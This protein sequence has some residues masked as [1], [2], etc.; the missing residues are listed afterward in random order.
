MNRTTRHIAL[1]S[2]LF[3]LAA[4]AMLAQSGVDS[5]VVERVRQIE[6]ERRTGLASTQS[7]LKT[8]GADR[9]L[10]G[11]GAWFS[12][13]YID[14][15]D[16]DRSSATRDALDKL[17]IRDVRAWWATQ[18]GRKFSSYL[19][20]KTQNFDFRTGQG[21]AAPNFNILEK[22]DLDMGYVEFRPDPNQRVRAGRQFTQVGRGFVLADILDGLLYQRTWGGWQADAFW[23]T[24]PNRI[25]NIDSSI[26][27]FNQGLTHRDFAYLEAQYTHRAGNRYYMYHV[28]EVDRSQSLDAD[29]NRSLVDFGYNAN[30]T[31]I[32]GNVRV[33]PRVLLLT[34]MGLQGGSTLSAPAGRRVDVE[35]SF[36]EALGLWSL[37]GLNDGLV[38]AEYAYGSGD[39]DRA[40]VTDT[41]GGKQDATTDENFL[42][43]G[44]IETGLALSPRLSN[45]HIAR[46]G[47]Q[48]RLRMDGRRVHS[49]DPLVGLKFT[50]YYKV[51][52]RGAISDTLANN[53][54]SS[55]VGAAGDAYLAWRVWSDT[56]LNVQYGHF[57]PGNAY[58]V[59]RR[60]G[61]D[62]FLASTTLSF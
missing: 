17:N 40:N 9:F 47:Y 59:G 62:R 32:G 24:T 28:S 49:T 25:L 58:P 43:F 12:N 15:S 36:F 34:E 60:S 41:F 23:G 10:S 1:A 46:V 50:E 33:T 5:S 13:T 45:L 52:E 6:Q 2:S 11:W 54:N 37:K 18:L 7:Y 14:F 30:F 39:P 16:D 53:A 21:T 19:R 42:Y 51:H 35:A 56:V 57:Q 29:P 55:H 27:G 4:G 3:A 38:Q 61:S 8:T 22:V 31:G 26:V 20:L 44:R 48:Q